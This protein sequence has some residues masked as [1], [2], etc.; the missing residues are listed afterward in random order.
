VIAGV[1][2][3]GLVMD[4]KVQFYKRKHGL[5]HSDIICDMPL[6]V[7]KWPQPARQV[8]IMETNEASTYR[9]EI[10]TDGSKAVGTVG[11]GVAIY[12]NKQL[13]VQRRYKLRGYCSNSQAVQTAILKALEQLQE[14]ETPT[15]GR[16]A[17]YTDS[18]VILDSLKKHDIRGYLIE[19]YETGSYI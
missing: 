6:P 5:E 16:A 1:P 19:I 9:I 11:A 8:T 18:K 17:I 10:Y 7:H 12:R 13:T 14:M 2:P 15:G 3:I 4:G